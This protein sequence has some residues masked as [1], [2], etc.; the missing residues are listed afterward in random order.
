VSRAQEL[1]DYRS[2]LEQQLASARFRI[3]NLNETLE[4]DERVWRAHLQ[5]KIDAVADAAACDALIRNIDDA[6]L[7]LAQEVEQR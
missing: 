1:L 2:E 5:A 7:E 3:M 6:L 4:E